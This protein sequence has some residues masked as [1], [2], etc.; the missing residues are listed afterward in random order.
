MDAD[1]PASGEVEVG[2]VIVG[3]D[4][5]PIEHANA[6]IAGLAR[7][8]PGD[9]VVLRVVRD[10]RERDIRLE[11]G[12]FDREGAGATRVASATGRENV[13]GFEVDPLTRAL[14]SRFGYED[15]TG[16]VI[17]S[18]ERYSSAARAGVRPGQIVRAVNGR[19]VRNDADFRE[20]TESIEDGDVVSLRVV[21]PEV[22]ETILNFRLRIR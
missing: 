8:D 5:Q 1:G 19:P 12:E 16:L 20:A 6:L 13:L 14:A 18:V 15:E 4:G 17:T 10:G 22:G 3:L 7:R 2:D 9:E 21:D 11:L